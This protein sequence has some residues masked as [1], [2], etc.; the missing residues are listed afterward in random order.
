MD[1]IT[2]SI[3]TALATEAGKKIVVDTYETLK[4]ALEKKFG[5]D[6]EIV[7]AVVQVEQEPDSQPNQEALAA[8]VARTHAAQDPELV[9]L[10]QS[11]I[12][13]LKETPQGQEAVR[14]IEVQNSQVGIVGDH[15]HVEGG[16]KF[17]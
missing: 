16:I 2:V 10:A 9:A 17:G 1:P 14:K 12:A 8:C 13:A 11:L 3:L 5:A 7:Q 4:S 6:S 15:A